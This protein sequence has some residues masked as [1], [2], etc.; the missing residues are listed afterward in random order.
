MRW[1]VLIVVA[2]LAA[3]AEGAP[4][5]SAVAQQA[6]PPMPAGWMTIPHSNGCKVWN[7]APKPTA[8]VTWTGDCVGGLASGHGVLQW[9]LNGNPTDRFEGELL[10]GKEYGVGVMAYIDG[11]RYEGS[12]RD[13]QRSGRGTL[14][15]PNGVKY[16]GDWKADRPH[17]KG[18][19]T[20]GTDIYSGAWIDGCFREGSQKAWLNKS[21]KE[22][23]FE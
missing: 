19:L 11:R 3:L 20:A 22:C 21:P 1:F 16:A 4:A 13:S 8:S 5:G 14:T 7:P 23:G 15:Y 10:R 12:F 18:T 2:S 6:V 17:G 9:L